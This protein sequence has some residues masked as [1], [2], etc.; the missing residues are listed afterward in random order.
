MDEKEKPKKSHSLGVVIPPKRK[1]T[2]VTQGGLLPSDAVDSMRAN[3]SDVSSEIGCDAI[4]DGNI[5]GVSDE[6]SGQDVCDGRIDDK[7]E[8]ANEDVG[9]KVTNE[10]NITQK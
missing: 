7:G 10:E 9:D 5:D 8:N 2:V 1:D 6:V 4:A 3:R